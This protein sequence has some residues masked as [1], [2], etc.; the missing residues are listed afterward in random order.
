MHTVVGNPGAGVLRAL[1]TLVL[2]GTW[3]C[4][5]IDGFPFF[6]FYCILMTKLFEPYPLPSLGASMN[7][8]YPKPPPPCP[9]VIWCC[10][11]S[12]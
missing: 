9:K 4:Q 5:K 10:N 11:F 7:L 1:A 12:K 3:G 6:V 8:T 2:G